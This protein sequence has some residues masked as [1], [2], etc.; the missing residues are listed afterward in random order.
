MKKRTDKNKKNRYMQKKAYSISRLL[1]T[2]GIVLS[3]LLV[4]FSFSEKASAESMASDTGVYQGE[5]D[6]YNNASNNVS[7][8]IIKEN[9][10]FQVNLSYGID[11]YALYDHASPVTVTLTSKTN[12]NGEIGVSPFYSESPYSESAGMEYR[13]K[14]SLAANTENTVSFSLYSLGSGMVKICLYDENGDIVYE[15]QDSFTLVYEG[16]NAAVGIFS[17]DFSSLSYFDGLPVVLQQMTLLSTALELK[18]EAF[19]VDPEAIG[20]LK[21]IIIDNFDTSKLSQQQYLAIKQWVG[22]GGTLICGLG[23]NYQNVLHI[24]NDNF[25]SG[26]IAAPEKRTI[27]VGLM[28][29][30]KAITGVDTVRFHV[31][32]GT[33]LARFADDDMAYVK[34]MGNGCIIVTAFSLGMEP[35]ASYPD[36]AGLAAALLEQTTANAEYRSDNTGYA[37]GLADNYNNHPKL[38]PV[39]YVVIFAIY[40][41]ITFPAIYLILKRLDKRQLMWVAIPVDAL[42]CT[43]FVLLI[44]GTSKMKKPIVNSF[45]TMYVDENMISETIQTNIICPKAKTYTLSLDEECFGIM[46]TYKG[47]Y[48]YDDYGNQKGKIFISDAGDSNSLTINNSG[49]FHEDYL[50][51]KKVTENNTGHLVTNLS[52][53]TDGF[54]GTVTNA[55]DYDLKNMMLYHEGICAAIGNLAAGETVEVSKSDCYIGGGINVIEEYY[56]NIVDIHNYYYYGEDDNSEDAKRYQLDMHALGY[57]GHAASHND[58]Y[59]WGEIDDYAPEVVNRKDGTN[60]GGALLIE[61]FDSAFLDVE[62]VY[63]PD[64]SVLAD[65]TDIECNPDTGYIYYLTENNKAVYKF[66]IYEKIEALT[67]EEKEPKQFEDIT[68]PAAQIMAYNYVTGSYEPIFTD[69]NTLTGEKLKDYVQNNTLMLRFYGD[70][71]DMYIPRISARGGQE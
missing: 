25:L 33:P 27:T 4:C 68:V 56:N 36:R 20:I 59:L 43:V 18:P 10:N 2:T 34:E 38:N 21:Y 12:F 22:R 13:R 6:A 64:I 54:E 71:N 50:Y 69:T 16:T 40:I 46:P 31:D 58:S 3:G 41:F 37:Q 11:G 49:A 45:T 65:Y 35:V 7:K 17:D 32:G 26:D 23:A 61:R 57:I 39:L 9:E 30:N 8:E 29:E 70:E 42:I 52:L 55:T 60:Y 1:I 67:L 47:R 15:E 62:G 28:G 66:G 51:M 14:I 63:Y 5:D 19:P 48:E 24:F 53:Y 44:G